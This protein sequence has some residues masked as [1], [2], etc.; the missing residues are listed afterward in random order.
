MNACQDS[1]AFQRLGV[2][3]VTVTA[4]VV[5][6]RELVT[7]TMVSVTVELELLEEDVTSVLREHWDPAH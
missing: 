6:M 1:L 3:L 2:V 4:V 5:T 7:E